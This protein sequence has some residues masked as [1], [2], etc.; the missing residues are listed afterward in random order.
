MSA[1]TLLMRLVLVAATVTPVSACLFRVWVHQESVRLGYQL[2][3]EERRGT[4]LAQLEKQL[5]LEL[6]AERSPTR[7]VQLAKQLGLK[8]PAPTQVIGKNA[9]R[10]YDA[11]EKADKT[12]KADAK[13]GHRG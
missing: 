3:A 9:K 13:A 2:S 8:A 12:A 10:L 1:G 4:E 5:E 6:A 11:P 7:L